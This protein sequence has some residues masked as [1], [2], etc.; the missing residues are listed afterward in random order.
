MYH[1]ISKSF[2]DFHLKV[3]G[4]LCEIAGIRHEK[5]RLKRYH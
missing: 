2:H 3:V 5:R 4:T 1:H